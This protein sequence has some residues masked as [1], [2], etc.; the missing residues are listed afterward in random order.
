MLHAILT[1]GVV[2]ACWLAFLYWVGE[3]F[4]KEEV[5]TVYKPTERDVTPN[6]HER[7]IGN[8]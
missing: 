8:C 3:P 1:Q 4:P 2:W 7:F 5:V 6:I